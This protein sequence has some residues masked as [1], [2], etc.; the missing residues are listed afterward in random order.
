[1]S[2]SKTATSAQLPSFRVPRVHQPQGRRRPAG[3]LVDGGVHGQQTQV[4]DVVAED[5][6][7]GAV[8][9][10]GEASPGR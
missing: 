9:P 7:E 2:G 1:M 6:D 10:G 4:T 8:E 3:H 5:P